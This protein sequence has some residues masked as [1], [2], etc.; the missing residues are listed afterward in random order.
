MKLSKH[1][2]EKNHGFIRGFGFG[3]LLEI[4]YTKTMKFVLIF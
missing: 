4:F 2:A 3:Y 1:E